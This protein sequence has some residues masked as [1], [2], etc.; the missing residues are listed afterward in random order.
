LRN[1][2]DEVAELLVREEITP[3]AAI[4]IARFCPNSGQGLH[5][6]NRY[7]LAFTSIPC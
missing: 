4:E 6:G 3:T 5:S 7:I 2:I 1:L